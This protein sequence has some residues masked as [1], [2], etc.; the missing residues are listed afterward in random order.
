MTDKMILKTW[1]VSYN[2]NIIKKTGMT[3]GAPGGKIQHG[4]IWGNN[5]GLVNIHCKQN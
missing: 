4:K 2:K 1:C 3:S 5:H